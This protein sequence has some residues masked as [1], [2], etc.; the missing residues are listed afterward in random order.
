MNTNK[1]YDS[2]NQSLLYTCI[3]P[4]V[5]SSSEDRNIRLQLYLKIGTQV[6]SGQN[7]DNKFIFIIP[8]SFDVY[9][10]NNQN[11][12]RLQGTNTPR[13]SAIAQPLTGGVFPIEI[14]ADGND[15]YIDSGFIFMSDE[16]KPYEIYEV[17]TLPTPVIYFITPAT[18]P[19]QVYIYIHLHIYI[20]I[21]V[22][23]YIHI[24][25]FRPVSAVK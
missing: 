21:Y 17:S 24:Y 1:F 25:V 3:Y 10:E 16:S 19:I 23:E 20:Y 6:I 5:L 8:F 9:S 18:P 11:N 13:A 14:S 22:Y 7:I 2:Y 12:R 4:Q 15:N